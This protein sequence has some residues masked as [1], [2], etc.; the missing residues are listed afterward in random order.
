MITKEEFLKLQ[1]RFDDTLLV[2]SMYLKY[3]GFSLNKFK[4]NDDEIQKMMDYF[5][6]IEDYEL[7]AKLQKRL[8]FGKNN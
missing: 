1:K 6:K 4:L 2:N 8:T 5:I 7:C 3:I